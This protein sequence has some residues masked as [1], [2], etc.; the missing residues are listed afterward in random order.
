MKI[1]LGL[2]LFFFLVFSDNSSAQN[3]KADSLIKVYNSKKESDTSRL[4]L[5][6][7]IAYA[8]Q[9]NNPDT[10][11]YFANQLIKL[12]A[13]SKNYNEEGKAN[14][15]IGIALNNKGDYQKAKGYY[16]SA[17]KLFSK[18]KENVHYAYCYFN[19]GNVFINTFE[20]EEAL[21]CIAKA[22]KLFIRLTIYL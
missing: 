18:E 4:S 3:S 21:S 7:S 5:L 10:A 20:Y 2:F 13:K 6:Y 9:I 15:M 22:E 11:I 8:Y 12:A 17:L 19:Q 16:E 1:F 14:L